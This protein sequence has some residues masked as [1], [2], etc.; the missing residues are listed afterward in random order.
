[1]IE[2]DIWNRTERRFAGLCK[3]LDDEIVYVDDFNEEI[4]VKSESEPKEQSIVLSK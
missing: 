4:E 1:V 2:I 3:D